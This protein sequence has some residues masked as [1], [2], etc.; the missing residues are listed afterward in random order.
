MTDDEK[1]LLRMGADALL[2]PYADL[3]N[4]LFGAAV[5]EMG[6]ML[7]E[8][9]KLRCEVRRAKVIGKLHAAIAEAQFEPQRIPDYIWIPALQAASLLDDELLQEAWANLLANSSD[10]RQSSALP[11]LFT[12]ILKDLAPYDVGFLNS[13]Y[14]G[15]F[16]TKL[17]SWAPYTV[18]FSAFQLEK[19]YPM[20]GRPQGT[21][22]D[23]AGNFVSET[24]QVTLDTLER[25]GI[26]GKRYSAPSQDLA[27]EV[28]AE[29]HQGYQITTLGR[30][31]IMACRP[32][33]KS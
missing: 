13:F 20:A 7:G 17:G 29:L 4:R 18:P 19:Y 32:P 6:R 22:T 30:N 27:A 3:V 10:P 15:V 12:A 26:I 11:P 31:F 21:S 25:G 16:G 33:R 28:S 23:Q 2:K 5:D 24:L 9:V 14:E 8:E 1:Q